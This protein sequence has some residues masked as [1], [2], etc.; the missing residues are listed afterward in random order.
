V[1]EKLKG[2][3]MEEWIREGLGG[4]EDVESSYRG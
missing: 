4:A 3:I 2:Q 1:A